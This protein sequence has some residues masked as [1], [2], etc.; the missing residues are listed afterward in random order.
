MKNMWLLD[1]GASAHFTNN[2]SDFI[3]YMPIAKSD[4]MPVKT[5]AHMIYVEGTGTVLLRHYIANKL[6]STYLL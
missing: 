5:A 2:I 3:N 4:R 1:S 6:Y